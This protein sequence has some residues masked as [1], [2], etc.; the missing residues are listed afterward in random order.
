MSVFHR[1]VDAYCSNGLL[2]HHYFVGNPLDRSC[3][4]G[5]KK[6]IDFLSGVLA[7]EDTQCL[8]C[9]S[10]VDRASSKLILCE[11]TSSAGSASPS[12][13]KIAYLTVQHTLKIAGCLSV[14]D[15]ILFSE[16][17]LLGRDPTGCWV[18]AVDISASTSS[19]DDVVNTVAA[20]HNE[21]YDDNVLRCFCDARTLLEQA[22][23]HNLSKPDIAVAG[24]ALAISG[25]H[26]MNRFMGSTGLP[27]VPVECGLKRSSSV[28][29]KEK[30][31]P[32]IDPVAI[33]LVIS[34]DGDSIL[35]GHMRRGKRGF[36]SCLSGFVEQCESVQEAV[37]REVK[38]ESGVDI[39]ISGVR[40]VDS[41]P[42][43]LGR[44][45]GCELMLGCIAQATSKTITIHDSDVEEVR[46]FSQAEAAALLADSGPLPRG[47]GATPT[48]NGAMV[49]TQGQRDEKTD[50]KDEYIPGEYAIAHHLIKSFVDGFK[51]INTETKEVE[52]PVKTII[53]TLPVNATTCHRRLR[54]FLFPFLM[55]LVNTKLSISITINRMCAE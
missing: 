55:F 19:H 11:Q 17:I 42:W 54:L 14:S 21:E 27:T 49:S 1:T 13:L 24:Q 23:Q 16:A 34:P 45:G 18:V 30:V 9:S 2:S 22:S 39:N 26:S 32:R 35:L 47:V 38:E 10:H 7:Q 50:D 29:A 36:F 51:D 53:P 52:E 43:P 20:C 4:T 40:L 25:W 15:L 37:C 3:L 5:N 44:G 48:S 41:Q 46:W 8:I 12:S 6:D 28:T 33:C 31:Y